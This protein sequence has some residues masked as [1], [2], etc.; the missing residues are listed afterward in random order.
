M[1]ILD[2][3]T[4]TDAAIGLDDRYVAHTQGTTTLTIFAPLA[5]PTA[6]I[7]FGEPSFLASAP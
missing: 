4:A 5:C 1:T 7:A 2:A 3:A 6:R